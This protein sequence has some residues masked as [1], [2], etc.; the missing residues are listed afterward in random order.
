MFSLRHVH[1]AISC[2]FLGKKKFCF[3]GC[4]WKA[5]DISMWSKEHHDWILAMDHLFNQLF[6]GDFLAYWYDDVQGT[7]VR[8]DTLP[9][10]LEYNHHE[11]ETEY[12]KEESKFFE[13]E[14]ASKPLVQ[15]SVAKQPGQSDGKTKPKK[16][17]VKD[18]VDQ[19]A[20][21]AGR[22]DMEQDPCVIYVEE[23]DAGQTISHDN[24]K[25]QQPS[26]HLSH[27]IS[28]QASLTRAELAA[29][30]ALIP[31]VSSTTS[32]QTPL[33]VQVDYNNPTFVDPFNLAQR[34]CESVVDR[35]EKLLR[36][37]RRKGN[38]PSGIVIQSFGQFS[39]AGLRVIRWFCTVAETKCK[40]AAEARWLPMVKCKP[41]ELTLLQD[42]LWNQPQTNTILRFDHKSIDVISFC[43]LAEERYIDGFIIDVSIG[44]H[45]EESTLLGRE[46]TLYFP[47]E[48]FQWMRA[49]DRAFKV[50]KLKARASRLTVL[51]D[52]QQILL[53]V[54]MTNHWGLIYVDL[55][56]KLLYFDDGLTSL[57]PSTA[58]PCVKEALD[59]LLELCPHHLSLQTKFW[60]SLQCFRRFGMPSQVP[61][62]NRMIGVG[63]C[64]IGVI[65]AARD[66]I[67]NG[68][69]TVN[70][71]NWRYCDMDIHRRD[72]MLQILMWGGHNP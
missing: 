4:G 48:F 8:E 27:A 63:S 34:P 67:R 29:L 16:P 59:L 38:H 15:R 5:I 9:S 66:F 41:M 50:E 70:N 2:Q 39:E 42:V 33:H 57:V 35:A 19:K 32:I 53:P 13:K 61:V 44:K 17:V 69:A 22:S 71:I 25:E 21:Q 43:D 23:V 14:A 28:T 20:K 1:E 12:L 36:D 7:S 62:D 26:T 55:S 30:G 52:L 51:A 60:H 18:E 6:G 31:P 68:S 3:P 24:V 65:M 58:L 40:V 64:G 45:L 10:L 56:G 72:L 49:R 54:F 46:G 37:E 47:T 11:W